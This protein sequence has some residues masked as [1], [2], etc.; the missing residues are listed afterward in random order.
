[1]IGRPGQRTVGDGFG[2]DHHIAGSA[3]HL[4]DKFLMCFKPLYGFWTGEIPLMATGNQTEPP[5]PG[6]D[7]RELPG[8]NRQPTM[9][10]AIL[11]NIVLMSIETGT[12][13]SVKDIT[14]GP[15]SHGD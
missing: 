10:L 14:F 2:E 4:L 3:S 9:H 7:I 11:K 6:I 1:M 8:D 12:G 5:I 15:F 13:R